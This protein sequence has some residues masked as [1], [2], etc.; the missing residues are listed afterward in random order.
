MVSNLSIAGIIFTLA[1]CFIP[2]F[3]VP[4][5]FEAKLKIKGSLSIFILGM[6]G[7]AISQL[8]I[9]T[10]I[11]NMLSRSKGFIDFATQFFIL[12]AFLLALSTALFETGARFVIV[13]ACAKRGVDFNKSVLLGAGH[14]ILE[15][16]TSVGLV[17]LNHMSFA[18]MI[19]KGVFDATMSAGGAAAA[20]IE[21]V[22]NTMIATD[23]FIFFATGFERLFTICIQIALT[24]L[25]FRFFQQK[26]I[27][28]GAVIC[29]ACHTAVN[30]IS[31]VLAKYL[32]NSAAIIFVA[33]AA[34]G[35]IY[36]VVKT[37][38]EMKKQSVRA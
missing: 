32:G 23:P 35:G 4:F 27:I 34:G 22:K 21:Y 6:G 33:L 30:F 5:Y 16:V 14:G 7:F 28:K 10:P 15:A 26:N 2:V 11:L 3:V 29:I 31:V 13:R 19:N 37:G 12:Y 8:L 38:K 1:V 36:Y 9:R 24:V 18:R 17:F 25:I 20:D